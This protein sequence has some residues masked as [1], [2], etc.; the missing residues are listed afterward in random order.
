MMSFKLAILNANKSID[1]LYLDFLRVS[2]STE[3]I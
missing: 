3:S 1:S 2:M